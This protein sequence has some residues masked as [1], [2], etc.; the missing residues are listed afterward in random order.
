MFFEV[1]I[2]EINLPAVEPLIP[3]VYRKA[4]LDGAIRGTAVYD[5]LVEADKL[6]GV[7]L[8]DICQ[9]WQKIEWIGLSEAYPLPK[10][11]AD[12]I[13]MRMDACD[14]E[15]I[16][17]GTYALYPSEEQ[18]FEEY[19]VDAGFHIEEEKSDVFSFRLNQ[20]N[21]DK[22][23]A[24]RGS[25]AKPISAMS[26]AERNS[27][28]SL[29]RDNPL[30]LPV[31]RKIIWPQYDVDI[32]CICSDDE[33]VRAALLVEPTEN[34]EL[35]ISFTYAD[36]PGD[37][38]S[39]LQ[40]AYEK[41]LEKFPEDVTIL[42]PI[43]APTAVSVLMELC[44]DAERATLKKAVF[45][46]APKPRNKIMTK[47]TANVS[48]APQNSDYESLSLLRTISWV[49]QG[50][51]NSIITLEKQERT[52]ADYT[53]K[54][55]GLDGAVIEHGANFKYG[56]P[57]PTNPIKVNNARLLEEHLRRKRS[58]EESDARRKNLFTDEMS[59][60]FYCK[61]A[62]E[63]Y[64]AGSATPR[65][66]DGTEFNVLPVS[67][68]DTEKVPR[69]L[70]DTIKTFEIRKRTKPSDEAED[71]LLAIAKAEY[72]KALTKLLEKCIINYF[73]ANGM[74]LSGKPISQEATAECRAA[75]PQLIAKYRDFIPHRNTYLL[76]RVESRL[77]PK[78]SLN[79]KIADRIKEHY[80]GKGKDK[81]S[82]HLIEKVLMERASIHENI[83]KVNNLMEMVRELNLFDEDTIQ[84]A[85][86]FEKR[87]FEQFLVENERFLKHIVT[88]KKPAAA[89]AFYFN[90]H[91]KTKLPT[92]DA[93]VPLELQLSEMTDEF[94]MLS[95]WDFDHV[96]V[97]QAYAR[98]LRR[99]E[100]YDGLCGKRTC[101]S[102]DDMQKD[103]DELIT[104]KENNPKI[105][106]PLSKVDIF[107]EIPRMIILF[108]K[109]K[110]LREA[111]CQI[112]APTEAQIE[113][114]EV[115]EAIYQ[116]LLRRST[117][118]SLL[119]VKSINELAKLHPDYTKTAYQTLLMLQKDRPHQ[120]V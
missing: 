65:E 91:Y 89:D 62:L 8:F 10:Y 100:E 88:G 70:A 58:L 75:M 59:Y 31:E 93:D 76:A 60:Q 90:S 57:A 116:T 110:D 46:F 28:L 19:L 45:P 6:V 5:D 26:E 114:A 96:R 82:N 61:K 71:S 64:K 106:E 67:L 14:V 20:V 68:S 79:A 3:E 23:N 36:N 92:L 99:M 13:R 50:E 109:A 32:S 44:P 72:E 107:S 115:T 22:L 77:T 16:L 102:D 24:E 27:F 15:G 49:L 52:R 83:S 98:Y 120:K 7:A 54:W 37:F 111:L 56:L 74:A 39:M 42:A 81:K 105:F 119:S 12:I 112:E 104:E 25:D 2:D 34:G 9:M 78:K 117:Y 63:L 66:L 101:E 43:L 94:D 85:H 17:F 103:Y 95:D 108:A 35:N 38:Y 29:V 18:V 4:L 86:Y 73:G 41:T 53:F 33:K 21:K 113:M 69:L 11:G 1:L 40:F 84:S 97:P 118:I 51:D 80:S 48:P 30:P 55:L 47:L 87:L